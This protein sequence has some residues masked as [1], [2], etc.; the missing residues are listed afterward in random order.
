MALDLMYIELKTG[1]ADD[2]PAWI[3]YVMTSKSGKTIYFNDH[4]FQRW[5]S[6]SGNYYDLETNEDYWIS[7]VKKRESNRH[8][9]GHGTIMVDSR[10]VPELL[11]II[12]EETLPHLFEVVDIED[13]FPVDRVA[14][15]LNQ[16][17]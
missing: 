10:A 15:L 17:K 6:S 11:D 9:A 16:K 7:G 14:T 13:K 5:N 2:G 1:Y 12:G 3:G 4:A 8:W